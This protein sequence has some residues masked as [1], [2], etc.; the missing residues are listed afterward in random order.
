MSQ[1]PDCSCQP[2]SGRANRTAAWTPRGE[3]KRGISE[4]RVDGFQRLQGPH[5]RLI[6]PA[7]AYGSR[8]LM[9]TRALR[10]FAKTKTARLL[11][12]GPSVLTSNMVCLRPDHLHE[13]DFGRHRNRIAAIGSDDF[14][15][16][17]DDAYTILGRIAPRTRRTFSISWSCTTLSYRF[18]SLSSSTV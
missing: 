13:L 3:K 18:V 7:G 16:R 10:F 2:I 6:W 5:A 15:H 17:N 4:K 1:P 9:R 8:R 14:H 12:D 11:R